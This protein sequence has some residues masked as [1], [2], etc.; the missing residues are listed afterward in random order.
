M[1]NYVL[2]WRS[3]WISYQNNKNIYFVDYIPRKLP[4]NCDFLLPM[5]SV[6]ITTDGVSANLDQSEVYNI[7][8]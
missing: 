4:E 7:K 6:P 3:Y 5:Q 8:W 2:R 1:F